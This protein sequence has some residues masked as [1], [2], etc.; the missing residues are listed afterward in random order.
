[1]ST[2]PDDTQ[3]CSLCGFSGVRMADMYGQIPKGPMCQAC[4]NLIVHIGEFVLARN[5][6]A[7]SQVIETT[8]EIMADLA[9]VTASARGIR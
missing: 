1:M 6:A 7:L 8:Y 9:P 5:A 2:Q 4:T 3:K